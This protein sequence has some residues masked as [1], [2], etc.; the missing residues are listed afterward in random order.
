MSHELRTPLNTIIGY[1]QVLSKQTIGPLNTKQLHY[2]N[3]ILDSSHHL[4]QLLSQ[5]LD[6][7]II[8]KQPLE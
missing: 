5:V 4:R 2:I 6:L 7:T 8:N 1:N 3:E